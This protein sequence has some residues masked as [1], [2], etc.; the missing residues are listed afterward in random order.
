MM[1]LAAALFVAVLAS[2]GL[3]AGSRG[4]ITSSR[5]ASAPQ[6]SSTQAAPQA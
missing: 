5:A 4:A 3:L 2:L 1:K 6:A